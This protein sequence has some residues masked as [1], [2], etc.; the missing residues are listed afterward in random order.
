MEDEEQEISG[1][2]GSGTYC[3]LSYLPNSLTQQV[4]SL[5]LALDMDKNSV[6]P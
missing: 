4:G 2:A 1:E 3:V 6:L 5:L